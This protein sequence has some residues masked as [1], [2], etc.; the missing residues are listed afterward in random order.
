MNLDT[1]WRLSWSVIT[2]LNLE[3]LLRR[4]PWAF[5][6][7]FV[8]TGDNDIL[9]HSRVL[10]TASTT[11]NS[12]WDDFWSWINI[13]N[14]EFFHNSMIHLLHLIMLTGVFYMSSWTQTDPFIG[15]QWRINIWL[16][17]WFSRRIYIKQSIN[18]SIKALVADKI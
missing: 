10:I 5:N 14:A 12:S 2:S 15:T 18:Q 9:R 8:G 4:C 6:F 17:E 3:T 7:Y 16:S 1:T 13:E 11:C